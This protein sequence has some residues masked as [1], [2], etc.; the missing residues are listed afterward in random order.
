MFKRSE[1]KIS[2]FFYLNTSY[3]VTLIRQEI[4]EDPHSLDSMTVQTY[5][6]HFAKSW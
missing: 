1:P 4:R 3:V 2:S 6:E 5:F